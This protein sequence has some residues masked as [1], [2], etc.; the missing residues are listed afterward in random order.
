MFRLE[1]VPQWA[2]ARIAAGLLLLGLGSA[3]GGIAALPIGLLGAVLL[4][5]TAAAML[6][7]AIDDGEAAGR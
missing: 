4:A 1:D 6:H 5:G 7:Q 2:R 3:V